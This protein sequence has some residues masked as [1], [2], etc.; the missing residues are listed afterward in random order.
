MR[1]ILIAAAAFAAATPA[2][3]QV[4]NSQGLV[5]VTLSDVDILKNFLNGAQISALNQVTGPI[6][7]QVPISVAADVCPDATIAALA[8]QRKTGGGASCTATSGSQALAD[9]VNRQKLKQN[10]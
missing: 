3:A 9:I 10:K 2:I 6:T 1:K 7:V 5:N 4:G 8:A